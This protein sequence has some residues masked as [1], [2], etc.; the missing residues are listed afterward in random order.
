MFH[1]WYVKQRGDLFFI[2]RGHEKSKW[3]ATLNEAQTICE[4][5]NR[6]I[7]NINFDRIENDKKHMQRLY[8]ITRLHFS[9]LKEQ[10]TY[11]KTACKDFNILETKPKHRK[12]TPAEMLAKARKL[13]L[14][15][16]FEVG[17]FSR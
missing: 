5:W 3:Y 7:I 14:H 13:L 2:C 11:F 9:M 17:R 6:K 10:T 16:S 4:D 12:K 8:S 15:Y 1:L